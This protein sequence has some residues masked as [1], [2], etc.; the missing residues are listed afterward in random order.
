MDKI[1]SHDQTEYLRKRY[2]GTN[3]R[4]T[5]DIIDYLEKNN[6]GVLLLLLDFQKAFD[7]VEWEFMFQTLA[8]FKFG[9][10]IIKWIQI[11]YNSPSV[12]IKNNG[13]LSNHCL[14]AYVKA[15]LCQLSYLSL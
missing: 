10:K 12:L 7:S 13:W 15:V 5:L 14:E 3:I 6:R 8:K 11:I 9:K 1:I 2:I 4:K